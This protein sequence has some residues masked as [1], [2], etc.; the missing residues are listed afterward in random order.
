VKITPLSLW[1]IAGKP[2]AQ[3]KGH[4]GWVFDISFSPKG[5]YLATAG[6][7]STTR[8]WNFQGKQL[9]QLGG[10]KGRV[11]S[12]SFSPEGQYLATA[13]SDDA[14]QLWDL[15]DPSRI[16]GKSQWKTNQGRALEVSLAPM[17]S[18]LQPPVRMVRLD[19]GH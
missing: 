15:S 16:Q 12:L 5:P 11:L 19:F 13:G 14:V 2:L 1:S 8:L 3:L 6:M 18:T 4:A 9:A 10:H 7:D 17:D